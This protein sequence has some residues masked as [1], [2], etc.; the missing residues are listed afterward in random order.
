MVSPR[1]MDRLLMHALINQLG[2]RAMTKDFLM[3]LDDK[4]I[5]SPS[6]FI[7]AKRDLYIVFQAFKRLEV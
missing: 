3:C 7:K 5:K 4:M 2:Y 1:Q 6:D